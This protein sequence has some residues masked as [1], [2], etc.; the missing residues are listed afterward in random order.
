MTAD[1]SKRRTDA[2]PH[3]EERE[4]EGHNVWV[5]TDDTGVAAMADD[6]DELKRLVTEDEPADPDREAAS[7]A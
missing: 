5:A 6:Q 7:D 2:G 1:D 4:F 3:I